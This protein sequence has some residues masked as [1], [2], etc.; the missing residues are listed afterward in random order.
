LSLKNLIGLALV[1]FSVCEATAL[2]DRLPRLGNSTDEPTSALPRVCQ[3]ERTLI[4]PAATR[5]KFLSGLDSD[6]CVYTRVRFDKSDSQIEAACD[7]AFARSGL[8]PRGKWS[9]V[10]QVPFSIP[11]IRIGCRAPESATIQQSFAVSYLL[12]DDAF[13]KH[14]CEK[15]SSCLINDLT[16][17][18]QNIL[19][20]QWYNKLGCGQ[21]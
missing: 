20:R 3:V 1:L 12:P 10:E 16:D 13:L 11:Q 14:Q 21:L 5:T 19:A 18:I 15:I 6:Q 2:G 4:I 17:P 7:R 9:C 8:D